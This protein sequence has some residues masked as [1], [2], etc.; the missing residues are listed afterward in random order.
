M[1]SSIIN[2]NLKSHLS[3]TNSSLSQDILDKEWRKARCRGDID[4][5]S[6]IEELKFREIQRKNEQWLAK[7]I[8]KY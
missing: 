1:N 7:M 3:Q 6:A 8:K 4:A 5:M 2:S